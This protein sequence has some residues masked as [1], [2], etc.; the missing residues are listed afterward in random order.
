MRIEISHQVLP[1]TQKL[2]E[3]LHRDP[4]PYPASF[5]PS[6][7]EDPQLQ[8]RAAAAL[9][10]LLFY[11]DSQ[12]RVAVSEGGEGGAAA[13]GAGGAAWDLPQESVQRLASLLQPGQDEVAQVCVCARAC[14]C[15]CVYACVQLRVCVCLFVRAG[16][17]VVVHLRGWV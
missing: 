4:P 1:F 15:V 14:I 9:G 17:C 6:Q 2:P 12:H 13:G 8:R 7:M 3:E 5:R 16:T 10:E 11:A